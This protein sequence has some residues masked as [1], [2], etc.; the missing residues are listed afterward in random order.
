[1]PGCYVTRRDILRWTAVAAAAGPLVVPRAAWG[2]GAGGTTPENLELVTLTED[3]A[4]VTWTTG[5]AGSRDAL[6]RLEPTPADAEVR[7]G[8]DPGRLDRTASS[9]RTDT[10]NHRVRLTGLEPGRTYYYEARSAGARAT[11]TP[12]TLVAGNAVGTGPEP[13]TGTGPFAFTT[14]QPPPGRF[15]FSVVLC[16]DMHVGETVA[17]RSG[18]IP[19]LEGVAQAPGHPPYPEVMMRSLVDDAARL[20]AGF[21][22]AAGDITAEAEPADLR[23]AREA[24]DRFGARHAEWFLARGNHDRA[25]DGEA[26]AS[27]RIGRWQ[28]HDCFVDQFFPDDEA[29]WLATDLQGLRVLGLDTYDKPGDGGDAGGM[30]PDQ[31]EWLRETIAAD[32]DRPTVVF[33][34]HPLVVEDSPYPVTDG[35]TLDPGQAATLVGLYRANPGVFLHHAGHTHRNRRTDLA[36]APGVVHQEV[37]AVKEYP[38]GFT[39]LRV[40]EGGYALNFHKASSD[41]ARAWSERSRTQIGGSWPQFA[42]GSRVAD[43][44]TVVE[45]DLSGLRPRPATPS[46]SPP[47]PAAA[48]RSAGADDGP[49]PALLGG[50][51]VAVAAAGAGSVLAWRRRT[52]SP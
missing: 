16:N 24:L 35:S 38:G 34:H 13:A 40:H 51:G 50:L 52:T 3:E 47:S 36:G 1:V 10:P 49:A 7:W 15:L 6:G 43:R 4:I 44:N 12:F 32:P 41:E 19:G 9:D 46:S 8:T 21:L 11:P 23:T 48:A 28:G 31:L 42:L 27:C 2:Q 20:G 37:A 33:G 5:L 29:T 39:L 22:L 30:S 26:Y 25:H 14:P 45:R 17:G 18:D